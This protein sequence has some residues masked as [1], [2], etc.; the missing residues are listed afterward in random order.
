MRRSTSVGLP[1]YAILG[2]EIHG[3]PARNLRPLKA[4]VVDPIRFAIGQYQGTYCSMQQAKLGT[5]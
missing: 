5:I 3:V 1:D 4:S 2:S